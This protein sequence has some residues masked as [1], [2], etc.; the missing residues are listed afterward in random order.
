MSR[1]ASALDLSV[2]LL[3]QSAACAVPP[4][5]LLTS[6]MKAY[7]S[8]CC[9]PQSHDDVWSWAGVNGAGKTTQ[10]QIITGALVP[11]EGE[12]IYAKPQMR[13][14]HLSQEFDVEPS[15]TVRVCTLT[16]E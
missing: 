12:V 8:S 7:I 14:A 1:R 6:G 11:D 15:R 3:D 4:A 10:L 2:C 5:A 13:I 16:A 9:L